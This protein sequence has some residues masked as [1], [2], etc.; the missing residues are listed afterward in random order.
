MVVNA[1]EN[2]G[3]VLASSKDPRVTGIGR[4]LRATRVD[5]LPQLINVLLAD[6]SLIGPRPERP[7][8]VRLFRDQLPG[9]EFRLA[10]KPGITGL[11]QIYGRYSTTPELKLRFDLL[12][13]YNYSLLMDM[14][15]LLQTILT[16]LQTEQAEGFREDGDRTALKSDE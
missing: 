4:F 2:T 9:Y 14:R 11:A 1:E 13:I 8:F 3:P 7:H 15:I 5:E 16:L 10:V 6:M 12:Y